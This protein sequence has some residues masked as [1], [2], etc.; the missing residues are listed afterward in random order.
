[1]NPLPRHLGLPVSWEMLASHLDEAG[2]LWRQ[3]RRALVA[4][5][6]V[7]DE[8][9]RVEAR[10]LAHLDALVLAGRGAATRLLMPA[11]VE[12]DE[13]GRGECAALGLLLQEEGREAAVRSVLEVLQ[14]GEE[15]PCSAIHAALLCAR[16]RGLE[17]WLRPMVDASPSPRVLSALLEVLGVWRVDP[18]PALEASFSHEAMQVRAAAFRCLRSWPARLSD[19]TLEVG[20][21]ASSAEVSGAALEVGLLAG[22]RLAWWECRRQVR[23]GGPHRQLAMGA[24]A[25]AGGPDAQKSLLEG[26]GD[27]S[28][29][30]ETLRVLGLLGTSEAARACLE[31]MREPSWAPLAAEAFALVTG[32]DV[33][34]V[35]PGEDGGGMAYEPEADLPLPEVSRV[36]AW[37]AER[38]SRFNPASRY[39]RGLPLGQVS[40]LD[41]LR[42]GA[43]Y[44]RRSLWWA[45]ALRT[46]GALGLRAGAWTRVQRAEEDAARRLPPARFAQSL[47]GGLGAGG[48]A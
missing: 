15:G 30:A 16:G 5:D 22:S 38:A 6:H 40:L 45:V 41:A 33:P 37:W 9:A 24:L 18:G 46:R 1:M 35:G 44:R 34:A 47:E 21:R 19:S 10:L 36:E 2:F 7:L 42:D 39:V 26:L 11:L 4:P 14:A 20:L 3:W 29:G 8:V 32:M 13:P 27:A 43:M 28:R 23:R 17:S 25:V 31:A 48:G 12:A